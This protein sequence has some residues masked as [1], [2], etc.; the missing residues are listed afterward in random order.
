MGTSNLDRLFGAAFPDKHMGRTV[1]G[2]YLKSS[3]HTLISIIKKEISTCIERIAEIGEDVDMK[4]ISDKLTTRLNSLEMLEVEISY[5][6]NSH[7][8]EE[9][10]ED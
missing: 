7:P 4:S 9:N 10:F 5:L 2:L 6:I 8:E 3:Y 1:R